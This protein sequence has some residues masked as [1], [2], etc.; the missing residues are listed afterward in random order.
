MHYCLQ[1]LN[2]K[3]N[4]TKEKIENLINEMCKKE[5]IT[6]TEKNSININKIVELTKSNLWQRMKN[7]KEINMEAPFY[8]SIEE[9][10]ETVLVQGIIDCYFIDSEDKLVLLDYKTDHVESEQE[11]INR[12]N[13]QLEIYKDALEK[14]LGRKV[15]ETYIYS[16]YLNKAIC[17]V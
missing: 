6:E 14:A 3:E 11:L 7:A 16:I 2:P 15:A 13:V 5:M 9:N 10:G 4:Y 17:M 12:Y 1:K 8:T